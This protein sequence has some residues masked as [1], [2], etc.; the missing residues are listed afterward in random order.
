MW[1]FR[2][3][4]QSLKKMQKVGENSSK[5]LYFENISRKFRENFREKIVHE[6]IFAKCEIFPKCFVPW[7]P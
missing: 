3:K 4:I 7:K 5:K 6:N 2:E 1:K